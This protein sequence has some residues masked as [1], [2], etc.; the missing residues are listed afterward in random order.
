MDKLKA[1][2]VRKPEERD[3]DAYARRIE[4]LQQRAV[5]L[6]QRNGALCSID[7][8]IALLNQ[9][10]VGHDYGFMQ[11][12]QPG[13]NRPQHYVQLV[14]MMQSHVIDKFL[15]K[16]PYRGGRYATGKHNG[17]VTAAQT[18]AR[19]ERG[20]LMDKELL[21]PTSTGARIVSAM[22]L[23]ATADSLHRLHFERLK[24]DVTAGTA[25]T[26]LE[27]LEQ[28]NRGRIVHR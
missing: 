23:P 15:S 21:A 8:C 25:P 11:V 28:E 9:M 19:I 16:H 10:V 12:R 6:V 17:T 20:G 7:Q 5:G 18:I 22:G 3:G 13:T 2:A 14:Q 1:Q 4:P 26:T 27:A 24:R